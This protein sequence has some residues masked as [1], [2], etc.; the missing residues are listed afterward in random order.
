MYIIYICQ[1][2]KLFLTL[3]TYTIFASVCTRANIVSVLLTDETGSQ[4]KYQIQCKIEC[5]DKL[6]LQESNS[7]SLGSL[8]LE[9]H[10]TEHKVLL[11]K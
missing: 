2:L 6:T 1:I 11:C 4:S 5:P 8:Y 9:P 10:N 7:S 3:Y